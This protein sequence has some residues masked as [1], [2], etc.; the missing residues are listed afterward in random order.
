MSRVAYSGSSDFPDSSN[1]QK[2][3]VMISRRLGDTEDIS[4]AREDMC[5][6]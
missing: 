5:P 3:G 1:S 4:I 6:S 2:R